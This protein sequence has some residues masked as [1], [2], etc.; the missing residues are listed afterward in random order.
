MTASMVLP[1]IVYALMVWCSTHFQ[2]RGSLVTIISML[3]VETVL[4]SNLQRAQVT[5]VL[6][7]MD[8]TLTL[9]QACATSSTPVSMEPPRS[10]PVPPD[11]GLTST[12]A[13]ATGPRPQTGRSA[14][15]IHMK[16]PADSSAQR[17]L[18]LM[19]LVSTTPT[20][21]MPTL[22]TVPSFSSA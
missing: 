15:L 14:R 12:V 8:S 17:P 10:T 18:P 6:V 9:T 13:S 20:P 3:T 1:R 4:T 16:P 19:S 22:T 2:G 5:F 21:S 11:S 7:S